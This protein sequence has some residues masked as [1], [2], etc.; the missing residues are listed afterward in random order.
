MAS[1]HAFPNASTL[2]KRIARTVITLSERRRY[3]SSRLST[4]TPLAGLG[5]VKS[6][7]PRLAKP[8]TNEPITLPRTQKR[9]L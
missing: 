4:T 8:K 1:L 9:K 5:L 6:R 2:K 3:S 7:Q